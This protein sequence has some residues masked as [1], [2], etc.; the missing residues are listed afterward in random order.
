MPCAF[1]APECAMT[2]VYRGQK[3]REIKF[4]TTLSS[5]M[6]FPRCR[7]LGSLQEVN[8]D[9]HISNILLNKHDFR[10]QEKL[11]R[12][13]HHFLYQEA[14]WPKICREINSPHQSNKESSSTGNI[15]IRIMKHVVSLSK[16]IQN[17]NR[18]PILKK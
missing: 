2:W 8:K 6:N 13:K 18:V 15:S 5:Q 4:K 11:K 14:R 12:Y 1:L 9:W 3:P 7:V 10:I 17:L 16:I